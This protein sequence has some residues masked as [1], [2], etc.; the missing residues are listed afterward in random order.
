M[1]SENGQP[2]VNLWLKVYGDEHGSLLCVEYAGEKLSLAQAGAVVANVLRD[3]L[4]DQ[5]SIQDVL[6]LQEI[7]ATLVRQ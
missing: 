3:A 4:G 2:D 1:P 5:P 7:M 6:Q